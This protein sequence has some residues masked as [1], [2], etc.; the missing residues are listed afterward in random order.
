MCNHWRTHG[1][2]FLSAKIVTPI[3]SILTTLWTEFDEPDVAVGV[4]VIKAVEKRIID[5]VVVGALTCATQ[6]SID[7]V[8]VVA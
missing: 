5:V 6:R 2:N 4:I 1:K 7:L 8:E 3:S